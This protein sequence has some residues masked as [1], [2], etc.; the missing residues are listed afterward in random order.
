[1][2]TQEEI[3]LNHAV[4]YEA[5]VSR[6]DYQGNILKAIREIANLDKLDVLDL[7]AGTGRLAC[8]LAPYARMMLA[9]DL[10]LP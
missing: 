10:S 9:F 8:L 2:P 7:G 3:Y 6:E 5:L 4:E 1:M